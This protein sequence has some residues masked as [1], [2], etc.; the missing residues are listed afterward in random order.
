MA[1]SS[2]AKT[3]CVQRSLESFPS[4]DKV[5]ALCYLY[6]WG[7]SKTFNLLGL[8]NLLDQE[9]VDLAVRNPHTRA[10]IL[11]SLSVWLRCRS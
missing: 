3:L 11:I 7:I 8:L 9:Y 2:E 1:S 5:H 4:P 10:E 6:H